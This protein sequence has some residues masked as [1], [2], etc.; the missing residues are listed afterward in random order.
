LAGQETVIHRQNCFFLGETSSALQ[1]FELIQSGPPRLSKIFS[2]TLKST[3]G[4]CPSHIKTYLQSR[5]CWVIGTIGYPSR[6]TKWNI[7][8]IHYV[9]F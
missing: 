6:D 7:S 8:K 3:D 2:F 5:F 4:S 1:V 9:K